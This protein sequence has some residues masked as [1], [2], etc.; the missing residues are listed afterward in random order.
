[1]FYIK[2]QPFGCLL[3]FSIVPPERLIGCLSFSSIS[4]RPERTSSIVSLLM[5]FLLII[6]FLGQLGFLNKV[7]VYL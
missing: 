7:F 1:M 5:F 4:P 3:I 2:K 6:E